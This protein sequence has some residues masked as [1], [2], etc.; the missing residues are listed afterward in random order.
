MVE[1]WSLAPYLNFRL[2]GIAYDGLAALGFERTTAHIARIA[3]LEEWLAAQREELS[4]VLFAAIP[5][6]SDAATRNALL[7][8]KRAIAGD[9]PFTDT[10]GILHTTGLFDAAILDRLTEWQLRVERYRAALATGD[11]LLDDELRQK[12]HLL[13]D[14]LRD[15]DYTKGILASSAEL[16]AGLQRY[17]ATERISKNERRAEHALLMYLS[18]MTVKP[19]PYATFTTTNLG[20]YQPDVAETL[21]WTVESMEKRSYI[22]FNVNA[23]LIMADAISRAAHIRPHLVPRHNPSIRV[24]G[25]SL[26]YYRSMTQHRVFVMRAGMLR[27]IKNTAHI[28]LALDILR[29][30][31]GARLTEWV[32]AIARQDPAI[33]H[34][35]ATFA[36][37]LIEVGLVNIVPPLSSSD[38]ADILPDLLAALPDS[39]ETAPLREIIAELAADVVRYAAADAEGRRRVQAD[40]QARIA[41]FHRVLGVEPAFAYP[42]M[43]FFLEDSSSGLRDVTLGEG[44]VAS[45]GAGL[46]AIQRMRIN[47]SPVAA[48]SAML[49]DAFVA[50]Y[51][52]GGQC[53]DL[54]GF[55]DRYSK[56]MERRLTTLAD[57]LNIDL[58][59]QQSQRPQVVAAH[60]AHHAYL[61]YFRQKWAGQ[62]A[63]EPAARV[64]T[65]DPAEIAEIEHSAAI[66]G[67]P[68]A[69]RWRRSC[70]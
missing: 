26:R 22:R 36:D 27:T 45:A 40:A 21:R 54:L 66:T 38:T 1:R 70:K 18:R 35:A 56:T 48:L 61:A 19:S 13:R 37:R 2:A 44:F 46:Q 47:S 65:V 9:N 50:D 62:Q 4:T 60:R 7:K 20:Q 41:T 33:G 57:P 39:V 52:I 32:A 55:F 8:L 30:M 11:A 59:V 58:L 23:A 15:P 63:D 64:M 12:R 29:D 34:N 6:A 25:D 16:Y 14:L 31:P 28:R 49:T 53:E 24:E 68:H 3:E 5:Q 51:G 67:Q 42:H 69:R 17:I 10:T 43:G